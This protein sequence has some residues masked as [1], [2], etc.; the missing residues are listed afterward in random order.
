MK[1]VTA[2][3]PLEPLLASLRLPLAPLAAWRL[4]GRVGDFSGFGGSFDVP[5]VVLDGGDR[6]RFHVRCDDAFFLVEADCFGWRCQPEPDPS[7][8][9]RTPVD[10]GRVRKLVGRIQANGTS[11]RVDGTLTVGKEKARIDALAGASAYVV[12]P[13][14]VAAT[15][16]DSHRVRVAAARGGLL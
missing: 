4:V 7:L 2:G 12:V 8:P 13:G 10:G 15:H 16:P 14:A 5:P 6:H 9:I 3:A 11:L 1:R